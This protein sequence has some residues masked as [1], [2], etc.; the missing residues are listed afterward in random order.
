[1]KKE[2]RDYVSIVIESTVK[3]INA[4]RRNYFALIVKRKK[5]KNWNH[6]KR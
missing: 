4:V 5:I 1:M 2:G 3:G 6:H